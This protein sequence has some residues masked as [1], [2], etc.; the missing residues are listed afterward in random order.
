MKW[1]DKKK[2]PPAIDGDMPLAAYIKRL[3]PEALRGDVKPSFNQFYTTMELEA[4]V[5]TRCG[6]GKYRAQLRRMDGEYTY[7]GYHTFS[8][9]GPPRIDGREVT[10]DGEDVEELAEQMLRKQA[11]ARV[12][13]TEQARRE[14]EMRRRSREGKRK[15]EARQ[16]ADERRRR[17][18]KL[19]A[20]L[21]AIE[22]QRAEDGVID[23]PQ[24]AMIEA[25]RQTVGA[26]IQYA[27]HGPRRMNKAS[28]DSG[29]ILRDA[30]LE[31]IR[32]Q[33]SQ[34]FAV[35]S[36]CFLLGVKAGRRRQLIERGLKRA[37]RQT[38]S[39]SK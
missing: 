32:T 34:T 8:L 24:Q 19:E 4:L 29:R 21:A 18:D 17:F 2:A 27:R 30:I 26:L 14:M 36:E 25:S 11:K 37:M 23:T 10:E 1:F 6:G 7:V 5:A 28:R 13:A 22:E 9:A 15:G 12:K 33:D 3:L 35:G 39:H 31:N 20:R 38:A 16:R